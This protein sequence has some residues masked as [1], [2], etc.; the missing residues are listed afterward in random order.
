MAFIFLRLTQKITIWQKRHVHFDTYQ[1]Y[2][3]L[4]EV[5]FEVLNVLGNFICPNCHFADLKAKLSVS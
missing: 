4:K 2:K 1:L 5:L 3:K